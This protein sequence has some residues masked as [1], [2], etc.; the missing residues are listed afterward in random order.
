[1]NSLVSIDFLFVGN[2]GKMVTYTLDGSEEK[3]D[4][5]FT[6][7]IGVEHMK[8]VLKIRVCAYYPCCRGV[9]S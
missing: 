5:L 3:H 9:G 6:I 1:M 2:V 4:L 7:D 8:N